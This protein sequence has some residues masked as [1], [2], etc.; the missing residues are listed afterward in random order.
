MQGGEEISCGFLI[1]RG[2]APEVFDR[3]EETFDKVALPIAGEGAIP[4]D[5]AV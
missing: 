2:D 3:V 4:F 5:D 1:A